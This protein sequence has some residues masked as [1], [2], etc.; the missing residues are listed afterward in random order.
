[1]SFFFNDGG[2]SKTWRTKDGR[3]IPMDKMADL[4]LM[5]VYCMIKLKDGME[6]IPPK[7]HNEIFKR[8]LGSEVEE[9]WKAYCVMRS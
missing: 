2:G 4:H 7:I 8:G 3:V 1:M 6:C 9:Y 5:N